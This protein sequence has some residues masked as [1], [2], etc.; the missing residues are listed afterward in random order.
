[1]PPVQDDILNTF[2]AKLSNAESMDP[3]MVEAL[4]KVLSSAKK[5]KPDE[6]VAVLSKD[7]R[8]ATP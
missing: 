8:G 5:L 2:C 6:V 1:M 7:P 4:R 3:A